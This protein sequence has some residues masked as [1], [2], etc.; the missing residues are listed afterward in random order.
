M[1]SEGLDALSGVKIGRAAEMIRSGRAN[2]TEEPAGATEAMSSASVAHR[3]RLVAAVAAG[4]L[5]AGLVVV[6]PDGCPVPVVLEAGTG[7]VRGSPRA[8]SHDVYDGQRRCAVGQWALGAS[9]RWSASELR[10]SPGGGVSASPA[11]IEMA[12]VS[13]EQGERILGTLTKHGAVSREQYFLRT[14]QNKSPFRYTS[15]GRNGGQGKGNR[16]RKA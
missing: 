15:R 1:V 14:T 4:V 16:T 13:R 6:D 5:D 2:E 12:R 8:G 9:D 11:Q 7:R 10:G 3:C